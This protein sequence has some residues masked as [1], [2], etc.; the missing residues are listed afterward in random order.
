MR[1]QICCFALSTIFGLTLCAAPQEQTPAAPAPQAAP[2]QTEGS[3]QFD[4]NRQVQR[5]TKKLNLTADQQQQL[6]P[7]LTD[8]NQQVQAILNDNSL[9]RKDRHE[10]MLAI[11]QDSQNKIKAVLTQEQ[12]Q[13]YD[14]MLQEAREHH[15]NK[16]SSNV[17]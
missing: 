5:L 16:K 14:Q 3:R 10:K 6:L 7:I 4:P 15:R 9:S 8:R 2:A 17:G 1:K 12:K 11:R 13:A